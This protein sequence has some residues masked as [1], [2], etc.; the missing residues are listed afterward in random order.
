MSSEEGKDYYEILQI[1]ANA[2][3]DTVHRVYRL[4]A[5]RFHPDNAETG[6]ESRFR[7]LNE[8]YQVL[9]DPERRAKFDVTYTRQRQ[10]RWRLVSSGNQS[11]NDFE[12]EQLLRLTVLEVLYTRR[13]VEPDTP[14]LSPLDLEKLTGR[15]REHLEFTI[16]YLNQKKFVVRGDSSLLTITAEGAEYLENNYRE[17]LQRRRLNAAPAAAQVG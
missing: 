16:W 2:E 6:N 4:L 5:Q 8:A 14:S 17:E 9:S 1:S 11:E 13:R 10:E 15:P 12:A 3:P 7:A